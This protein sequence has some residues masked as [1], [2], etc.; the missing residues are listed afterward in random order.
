[1]SPDPLA[2]TDSWSITDGVVAIQPPRPGDG[3]RLIAGRDAEWARWMGPGGDD[4]RPTACIHVAGQLVGWV[5]Y[6]RGHPWLGPGEVNVGYTVFAAHRGRGYATRAVKLLVHRLAL[7]GEHSRASVVIHPDNLA[8]IRVAQRSGFEARGQAGGG[9][10]RVRPVPPLRYTDGVVSIRR[11]SPRDLEADLEAKDEAQIRWM[12]E[13][14]EREQWAAM[15][16]A[17]QREHARRGLEARRDAFGSGPKWCFAVD[18]QAHAYVAYVDCDLASPN[19]PAGEA[20]LAYSCHPAHRGRGHVKRAVRLLLRFVAE[21]TG[22]RQAH[23]VLDPNNAASE[24][25]ARAVTNAE[26]QTFVNA[27]GQTWLRFVCPV[28]VGQGGRGSFWPTR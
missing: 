25:V 12:W 13:P 11:L 6:A 7:E 23:V 3:A 14:G 27:H 1:M 15:R 26:P 24:R 22:A 8:S 20:N 19:A 18:T 16:P 9:D 5:D 10:Y 17:E 21:H 4:P 28:D 2:S